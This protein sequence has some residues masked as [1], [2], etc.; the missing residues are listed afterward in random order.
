MANRSRSTPQSIT[1]LFGSASGTASTSRSAEPLR[2][3]HD[4]RGTPDR[5]AGR[6][7]HATAAAG[8]LDVLS[9]R[10]DDERGAPADRSEKAGGDE[11]VGVH[12]VR[13]GTVAPLPG[14][15][16]AAR[17]AWRPRPPGRSTTARS[18]S[19]PRSASALLES[20]RRTSRGPERRAPGTSARRGG[21]ASR[22]RRV[23]ARRRFPRAPGGRRRSRRPC[24]AR[25]GPRG[26]GAG[27]CPCRRLSRGRRQVRPPPPRR[28]A[29]RG[30]GRCARAGAARA[31]GSTRCSSTCAS[32]SCVNS[33]TPTTRR[34]RPRRRSGTGTPTP[35][36][37]PARSRPRSRRP[38]RRARR[39]V[40]SARGRAPRARP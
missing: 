24:S 39:P 12:D 4:R 34:C 27:G 36:S 18:I 3:G 29:R 2:H 35:R 10:G 20:R 13:V 28:F 30:H 8:V 21:C 40:R 15:R 38:R 31:A 37:R 9:V 33:F 25:G 14:A 7:P 32:D 6:R 11:E 5:R 16:R 17:R 23:T 26:A 22:A 19:W 1:E